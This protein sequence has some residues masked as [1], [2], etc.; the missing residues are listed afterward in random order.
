MRAD[1]RDAFLGLFVTFDLDLEDLVDLVDLDQVVVE[2]CFTPY[3][4][5]FFKNDSR[6]LLFKE[7]GKAGQM[8]IDHDRLCDGAI[9]GP[10]QLVEQVTE[11]ADVALLFIF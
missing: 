8:R 1:E 11:V 5:P 4:W 7:R 9:A 10:A 3:K 6:H 2:G